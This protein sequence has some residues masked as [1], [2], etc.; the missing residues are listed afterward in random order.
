MFWLRTSK[1]KQLATSKKSSSKSFNFSLGVERLP[2]ELETSSKFVLTELVPTSRCRPPRNFTL[3][4]QKKRWPCFLMIQTSANQFA[5]NSFSIDRLRFKHTNTV[6]DFASFKKQN[7]ILK[8]QTQ[9]AKL[10]AGTHKK[11]FK[12]FRISLWMYPT[13]W[14]HLNK[15]RPSVPL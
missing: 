12:S 4:F 1:F 14:M 3:N 13:L 5:S 2:M 11:C 10:S 15:S 7:S 9:F 6:L 8:R